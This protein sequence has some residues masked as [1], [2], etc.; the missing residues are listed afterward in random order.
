MSLTAFLKLLSEPKI[1]YGPLSTFQYLNCIFDTIFLIFLTLRS[2]FHI[3]TICVHPTPQLPRLTRV[4]L[5]SWGAG[6]TIWNHIWWQLYDCVFRSCSIFSPI[7]VIARVVPWLWFEKLPL[8][9]R[10]YIPGCPLTM[11][12]KITTWL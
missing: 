10:C 5:S 7:G 11:V 12:W 6:W 3:A 9:Y 8:G 4:S 1:I 2:V